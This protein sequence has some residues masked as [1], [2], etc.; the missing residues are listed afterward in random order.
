MFRQLL[1]VSWFWRQ[2]EQVLNSLGYC[3]MEVVFIKGRTFFVVMCIFFVYIYRIIR[4]RVVESMFF[5]CILVF[6]F[7]RKLLQNMV[8]KQGLLQV[9]TLRWQG[10]F[11]VLVQMFILVRILFCFKILSCF[12]K[13]EEK[14]WFLKSSSFGEFWFILLRAGEVLRGSTCWSVWLG[15]F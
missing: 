9:S 2:E 7:F 1:G 8:L 5:S 4:F 13:S 12:N 11:Q 14:S 3:S 10:V 6:R 15:W